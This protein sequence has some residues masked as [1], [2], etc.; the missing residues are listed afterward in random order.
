MC[1]IPLKT[2]KCFTAVFVHIGRPHG[3]STPQGNETEQTL[4][5]SEHTS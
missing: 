5:E 3:P 2:D 4:L 1:T